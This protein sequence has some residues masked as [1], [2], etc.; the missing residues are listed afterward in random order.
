MGVDLARQSVGVSPFRQMYFQ[1]RHGSHGALSAGSLKE[2]EMRENVI[3]FRRY[4]RPEDPDDADCHVANRE[5][6]ARLQSPPVGDSLPYDG[7]IG[8]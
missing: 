2:I 6:L 3:I 8:A 4:C 7:R 1:L 5:S